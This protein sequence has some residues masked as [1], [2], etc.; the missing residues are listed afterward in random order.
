MKFRMAFL[1]IAMLFSMAASAQ[2]TITST[3]SNLVINNYGIRASYNKSTVS[4]FVNSQYFEMRSEGRTILL[5][6]N[7]A[8]VTS[9][10]STSLLD[11][12]SKVLPLIQDSAGSGSAVDPNN[13]VSSATSQAISTTASYYTFTGTTA[14]YTLPPIV[15]NTKL[16]VV[17]INAGSGAITLNTNSGTADISDSG[18]SV[19]TVPIAPGEVY[20]LYNNSLKYVIIP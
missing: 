9:P 20:V 3:G 19:A 17:I 13:I 10:V 15:G 6:K 11:L 2:I 4:S 18:A 16:R 14:I 7:F 1:A 8:E 5:V 12:Q